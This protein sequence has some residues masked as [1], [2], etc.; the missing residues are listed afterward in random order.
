M[1]K[2]QFQFNPTYISGVLP[3]FVKVSIGASGA[4]TLG[5]GAGAGEALGVT[6]VSGGTAASAT[7]TYTFVLDGPVAKVLG[8]SMIV[9]NAAGIP[10]V[11]FIGIKSFTAATNTLV[12]VTSDADTPAAT[13]PVNGD[14]L[15]ITLFVKNT[16]GV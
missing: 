16:A 6:S 12:L 10:T 14:V 9:Q 11:P 8:A 3:I 4:P 1:A 2:P 5:T 13:D 7:G 15:F